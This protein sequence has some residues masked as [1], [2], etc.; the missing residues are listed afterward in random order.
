VNAAKA[1]EWLE[2]M[3]K[4]FSKDYLINELNLPDSAIY[5]ELYD[6]SRWSIIYKIIFSDNGKFYETIYMCGIMN[7]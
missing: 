2:Q 6:T 3:E 5:E 1:G 4:V 7:L